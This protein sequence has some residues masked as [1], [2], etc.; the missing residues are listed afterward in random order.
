MPQ[1]N[2]LSQDFDSFY[3]MFNELI[4]SEFPN[5][6]KYNKNNLG[7]VFGKFLSML[8]DIESFYKDKMIQQLCL[9]TVTLRKYAI[10][11][12][13]TLGYR[14]HSAKPSTIEQIK[15]TIEP[16]IQD[17]IIPA[18][19][20][21][22]T[23]AINSDGE[24][25]QFETDSDLIIPTG[26]TEG[27]VSAT[28]GITI[29]L[30]NIGISNGKANQRFVLENR[31]VIDGSYTVYVNENN[32]LKT[33][34]EVDTFAGRGNEN[35]FIT[36]VD[37]IDR[38]YIIFGNGKI[39]RIPP[40]GSE[41][42]CTYRIGGGEN[43]N[44]GIGTV[45]ENRGNLP[46]II[47][48]MNLT[49]AIGGTERETI[50]E[51]KIN[52]PI[53]FKNTEK[54]VTKSDFKSL[55]LNVNGVK[56]AQ[57][58]A[59]SAGIIDVRIASKDNNGIPTEELKNAV[60]YYLNDRKIITFI[61]NVYDPYFLPVNVDIY[62]EVNSQYLQ[63]IAQS[64]ITTVLNKLL[65]M[66]TKDFGEGEKLG[67]VYKSI[68]DLDEIDSLEITK[69]TT[70]PIV[71]PK[72]QSANPLHTFD[73]VEVLKDNNLVGEWKVTMLN[74]TDFK[75]EFY[76][77]TTS[78]Y[79]N[80]GTGS[81]GTQFTSLGNEIRFTITSN[82]GIS[83]DGDYWLFYTNKYLGNITKVLEQELLK[84]GIYNIVLSGGISG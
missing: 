52:A 26:Q 41:I 71:Y 62:A 82:G 10:L 42:Y 67:V 72:T 70:S 51:A 47:S 84:P 79:I 56:R 78:S 35:I 66:E 9:P 36:E 28:Q 54:A 7:N 64:A 13:K 2:Y 60:K 3:E 23:K 63:S 45:T 40:I 1:I 69:F 15:F 4:S 59:G 17:Y 8:G 34:T 48:I 75:V 61:I 5:W 25:I 21:V 33:W 37:E 55:C 50:E 12:C 58:T 76:D 38:S 18:G 77:E 19:Y 44:V 20:P 57:A 39:G 6:S 83:S 29:S 22:S 32:I 80:K 74:S 46:N 16:Q 81:I 30:E 11:L 49:P 68:L 31:K 24:F 65:S 73:S 43:T 27:I 53:F 14:M